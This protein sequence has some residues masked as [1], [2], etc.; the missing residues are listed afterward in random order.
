MIKWFYSI[1]A[2]SVLIPFLLMAQISAEDVTGEASQLLDMKRISVTIGGNF[3]VNGTFSSSPTERLDQF[4][5]RV[6][7]SYRATMLNAIRD[8]NSMQK[9]QAKYEKHALRNIE[10]LRKNGDK[11]ILDLMKFRLDG[12]FKKN[13]YLLE[14]DLIIFPH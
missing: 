8:E 14:G 10:L 12:D 4:V 3:I 5:T 6:Y 11:E 9:F 7:N 13:P 2:I 1:I